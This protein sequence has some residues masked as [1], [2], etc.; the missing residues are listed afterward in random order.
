MN[1]LFS[2]YDSKLNIPI[3]ENW[4]SWTVGSAISDKPFVGYED[5]CEWN[6]LDERKKQVFI[7]TEVIRVDYSTAKIT[8]YYSG[9]YVSRDNEGYLLIDRAAAL[10]KA[11]QKDNAAKIKLTSDIYLSDIPEGELCN[12]FTGEI[13]GNYYTIFGGRPEAHHDAAHRVHGKYLFVYSNGASFSN[14][15]FKDLSTD[16]DEHSNWSILT[17]QAKNSVF[18]GIT[19]ENV[20]VSA[21]KNNVGAVAGYAYNSHFIDIKVLYGDFTASGSYVGSVVGDADACKFIKVK[22][23]H[24]YKTIAEDNSVGG[25]V[26]HARNC[27]FEQISVNNSEIKTNNSYVGGI[28]GKAVEGCQFR[29]I[30]V[31]N[32]QCSAIDDYAGGIVGDSDNSIFANIEIH[33]SFVT[34]DGKWVGGVAGN[35][36]DSHYLNC[37]TDDQS[38]ICADGGGVDA[39]AGGIV[40]YSYGEKIT[41][42][43]NSALIATDDNCA[44]GIV[45]YAENNGIIED[46]L[47]T[48]MVA[49]IKKEKVIEESFYNNYKNAKPSD[50]TRK[51]YRG[52]E[53]F[54]RNLELGNTMDISLGGI[55][56]YANKSSVYRSTNFGTT[57]H[58]WVGRTNFGGIVGRTWDK[59]TIQDCLND[60]EIESYGIHGIVGHIEY[61]SVATIINCVSTLPYYDYEGEK[62]NVTN[63][64]SQYETGVTKKQLASGELVS[65][66]GEY[67]EQDLGNDPCPTPTGG[68]GVYHSRTVE[69]TYGTI[70]LPF[71]VKSDDNVKFYLLDKATKSGDAVT[72]HFSYVE[73]L[74]AGWP[75]LFKVAEPGK[76]TLDHVGNEWALVPFSAGTADAGGW[77]IKGTFDETVFTGETAEERY[78]IADGVIRNAKDTPIPPYHTYLM[79]PNIKDME[80]KTLNFVVEGGEPTEIKLAD[81][82]QNGNFNGKTYS[83]MGTQVNENYRGIVIQNGRKVVR[84]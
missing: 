16:T 74:D 84:R 5:Y 82:N 71:A 77:Y 20:S 43:T 34:V 3:C 10:K 52:V 65:I 9:Y 49:S 55:V 63:L 27:E 39:Y 1:G 13:I 47:N 66:L 81:L 64:I 48:G 40:G 11:V 28:A 69:N 12:T 54:I 83:L 44:G 80:G 37:V 31:N 56:G 45:G 73:E 2:T 68:R 78:Y 25:I 32:I 7:I 33:G 57:N 8:G 70:C 61:G 38:C 23:D 51:T 15:I 19:F 6:T 14:L 59:V 62:Y 29:N 18:A 24:N 46:C 22:V 42:C 41:F 17:S 58:F 72:L 53:Y 75:A 60:L 4:A 36:K 79:G 35:S 50:C 26:G 21:K 67:W 30:D 76:I